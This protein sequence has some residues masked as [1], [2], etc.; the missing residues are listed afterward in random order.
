MRNPGNDVYLSS[1]VPFRMPLDKYPGAPV[2][3]FAKP[4]KRMLP[5]YQVSYH[6]VGH[7]MSI[8]RAALSN[9]A[10]TS[11]SRYDWFHNKQSKCYRSN[12][13]RWFLGCEFVWRSMNNNATVKNSSRP[14]CPA[15]PMAAKIGYHLT[16][17][18]RLPGACS[19]ALTYWM[20]SRLGS[21]SRFRELPKRPTRW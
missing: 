10:S 7:L 8:R 19:V 3:H 20:G 17:Q 1:D 2:D 21:Q 13:A 6:P 11:A 14:A 12:C 4:W 16:S 5:I 18:N 15:C 9:V